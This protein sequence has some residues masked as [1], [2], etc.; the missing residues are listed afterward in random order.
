M[1]RESK[2][3]MEKLP[4]KQAP[5]DFEAEQSYN[6]TGIGWEE[7]PSSSW[8]IKLD[9]ELDL[10]PNRPASKVKIANLK[11]AMEHMISVSGL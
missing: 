1:P 9:T 8:P 4:F 3:Y 2:P 5:M 6:M 11:R 7:S 10:E